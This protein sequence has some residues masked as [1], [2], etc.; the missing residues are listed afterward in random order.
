VTYSFG[1]VQVKRAAEIVALVKSRKMPMHKG[2]GAIRSRH[3]IDFADRDLTRHPPPSSLP[4][5]RKCAE[6]ELGK[7][8]EVKDP[9][10]RRSWRP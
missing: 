9:A 7:Q 3:R 2:C 5:S 8:M 1:R 6:L 10:A 4:F